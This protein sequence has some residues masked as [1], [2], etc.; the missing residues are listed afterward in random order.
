[1]RTSE[2]DLVAGN[3]L[4]PLDIKCNRIGLIGIK[5]LPGVLICGKEFYDLKYH[6]SQLKFWMASYIPPEV[7]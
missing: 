1:M 3:N 2:S 6:F 7:L 5:Q 4:E